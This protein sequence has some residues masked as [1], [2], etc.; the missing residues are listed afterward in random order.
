MDLMRVGNEQT[1]E[2]YRCKRQLARVI[3]LMGFSSHAK[4]KNK[5]GRVY[6]CIAPYANDMFHSSVTISCLLKHTDNSHDLPPMH[7]PMYTFEYV[8]YINI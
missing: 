3:W 2:S 8:I 1:D 5:H 4:G 7:N 6:Y